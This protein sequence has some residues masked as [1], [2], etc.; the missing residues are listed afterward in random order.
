[1]TIRQPSTIGYQPLFVDAARR[2]KSVGLLGFS[3]CLIVLFSILCALHSLLLRLLSQRVS[4]KRAPPMLFAPLAAAAVRVVL[5]PTHGWLGFWRSSD[6]PLWLHT[7]AGRAGVPQ[8]W[9]RSCGRWYWQ[10]TC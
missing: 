10:T 4:V 2:S 3:S 7:A 5:P 9:R 6:P 8:V 1:M